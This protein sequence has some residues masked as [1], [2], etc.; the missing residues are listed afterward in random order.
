[1]GGMESGGEEAGRLLE[2]LVAPLL[3]SLRSHT[4]AHPDC[5]ALLGTLLEK[6]PDAVVRQPPA[7]QRL[8]FLQQFVEWWNGSGMVEW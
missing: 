3:Q 1:M 4:S 5:L 8:C 7:K 2:Q 6:W